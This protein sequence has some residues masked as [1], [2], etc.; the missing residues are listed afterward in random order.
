MIPI[1]LSVERRSL[2]YSSYD[3]FIQG[4]EFIRCEVKIIKVDFVAT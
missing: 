4:T 2:Q 1:L 3:K